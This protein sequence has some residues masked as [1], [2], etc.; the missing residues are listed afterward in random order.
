[1]SKK[2]F[3]WNNI[4]KTIMIALTYYLSINYKIVNVVK[5]IL[6]TVKENVVNY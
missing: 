2:K 3:K 4:F 5:V 6:K 1:M